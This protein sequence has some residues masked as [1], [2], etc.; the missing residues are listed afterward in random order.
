MAMHILTVDEA[1][2]RLD[3]L[4]GHAQLG[5]VRVTRSDGVCA[6]MVSVEA[7]EAMR[8]QCASRLQ[9][10]IKQSADAA[11]STGLTQ[12]TLADLLADES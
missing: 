1:R 6:V 12:Q 7:Y 9:D 5:P 10:T 8:A 2:I 4:L 3:E 11:T